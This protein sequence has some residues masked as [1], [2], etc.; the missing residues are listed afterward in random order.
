MQKKSTDRRTSVP[1]LERLFGRFMNLIFVFLLVLCFL[2]S[3]TKVMSADLTILTED[4]P[5]FNFTDKG[6][7]TG[8]TTEVVREILRRQNSAATI[9]VVPWARGYN[10]L[11]N[12]PNVVLFTTARTVE[13]EDLV[14]WVGPIYVFRL[15]FYA[16][17]EAN[18]NI[19]SLE[20]AKKVKAIA[21]YKEDFGEQILK[22]QGFSNLDSSNSPKSNVRKLASGRVDLW[23]TDNISAPKV[24][25][26]AGIDPAEL[27]EIYTYQQN[28]SY[29]AISKKTDPEV[30]RQW[31]E[32]LDAMK[33]DGTFWWMTRKWLP[34]NAITVDD[35]QVKGD[36]HSLKLYTENS[37]PSSY[38]EDGQLQGLSVEIVEEI[39]SRI[40]KSNTISLV[41]WAR[42]YKMA[43]SDA[44][45]ALFSTTKLPQ[46]DFSWVGPL[47]QQRWGFYRWKDSNIMIAD[48]EA[49]KKVQRIG[50]YR[51][52]AKMLYLQDMGFNNLVPSNKNISNIAHLKKGDIDLWVSSD[53]NIEHLAGQAGVM[54][55]QL[56]LAY[57]FH[58][59]GNYIAFSKSTSPHVIHLWQ[60]VLEE[61][62]ADGS[63]KKICDRYHYAP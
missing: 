11:L 45:V 23:F 12:D 36:R 10:K 24:A 4:F 13:R 46:R 25:H 16:K 39:L 15:G 3:T 19:D 6:R 60:M 61:M 30:V 48:I 42:G 37:P 44:R 21:T 52:D 53:F 51:Q 29:I 18:L 58:T 9:E 34:E 31:Q 57:A 7:L 8:V 22:S 2:P 41:P 62:K 40:G 55:E 50:T 59:V 1:C 43:L 33:A 54:S 32:T 49:A 63:Y 17:K 5:P 47:Y 38:L 20:S 14:Q 35:Y 27:E 28:F 56:V 26:K